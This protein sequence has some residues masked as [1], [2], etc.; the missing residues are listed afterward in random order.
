LQL[1]TEET[2]FRVTTCD[3]CGRY[4]KTIA[5]LTELAGPS[6]L[7]ADAATLHLNLVAAER[8]YME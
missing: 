5:T 8:G 6:L 4:V 7:A 1:A 2:R 3:A